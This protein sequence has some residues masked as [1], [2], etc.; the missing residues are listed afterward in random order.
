MLKLDIWFF[1]QLVNFLVLVFILNQVLF[2]PLLNLFQERKEGIE[3]SIE[4]AK[5]LNQLKDEEI[6]RYNQELAQAREHAKE[7]YNSLRQEGLHKQKEIIE[8]AHEEAMAEIRMAQE[9]IKKETE[10]VRKE[11]GETVRR[12]S[13]E[14]VRKLVEV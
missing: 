6:K 1:V 13:E 7:I 2:K 10:R 11:L 12:F 3:G 4:E 8:K 14:I 5:R 9:A